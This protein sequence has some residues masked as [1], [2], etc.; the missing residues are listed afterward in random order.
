MAHALRNAANLTSLPPA[1]KIPEA[2]AGNKRQISLG[3]KPISLSGE[4]LL[5]WYMR[6][7][8]TRSFAHDMVRISPNGETLLRR[9]SRRNGTRSLAHDVV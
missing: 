3:R 4:I 2:R 8:G 9:Y 6:R 5:R 1:L 7:V